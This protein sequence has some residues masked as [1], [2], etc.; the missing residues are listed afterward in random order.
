MLLVNLIIS[1]TEHIYVLVYYFLFCELA[2]C[3]RDAFFMRALYITDI[4]N[5][6]VNLQVYYSSY[7]KESKQEI[8]QEGRKR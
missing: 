3:Y 5:N 1:K 2:I 4:L 7:K 8:K 6:D